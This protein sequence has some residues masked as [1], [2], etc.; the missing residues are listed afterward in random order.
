MIYYLH[1][2]GAVEDSNVLE[3]ILSVGDQLDNNAVSP[4]SRT[5]RTNV[6]LLLGGYSYGSLIL[7]RLP[8]VTTIIQRLHSA[9]VGTAGAEI[10]LR[11]RTLAKQTR[12]SS[13]EL[14]SPVSAR[15][16][17]LRP[18]DAATSPTKRMGASPI[19]VG[20][21]ETDPSER[22]RS[23]DSRRSV[24]LVRKSVE[25][26]RRIRA[27][28]IRSSTPNATTENDNQHS[29]PSSPTSNDMPTVTTRYLA[30]SPV[31]LPFTHM[32]CPPGPPSLMPGLRRSTSADAK[33]G[34]KFLES[35]TLAIFGSA[36][37][38]TASRR[39][40]AWAQ[41]MSRESKSTF[42]W[43]EIEGAGHFWRETGVMEA[44]QERI[45]AWTKAS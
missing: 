14:H 6:K 27:H 32:L 30:I 35:P 25:L 19:T 7:A 21:E 20:G 42:V 8:A 3:P 18:G 10:L 34:D 16:R 45:A 33:A 26:P 36:D 23:R 5:S 41:K 12:H 31:L 15:G 24:D 44:L 43:H 40:K 22:R 4:R 28:V 17:S 2:L 29:S 13:E 11:A 37:V 9:D 1:G 38:F 39:L